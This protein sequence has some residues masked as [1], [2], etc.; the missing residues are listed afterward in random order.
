[1][2][3]T[4]HIS[5][6]CCFCGGQIDETKTKAVDIQVMLEE[7]AIQGLTAHRKCLAK[8]L[9]PSVPIGLDIEEETGL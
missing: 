1:M 4:D 3:K 6:Q 2:R 5:F 8:A 9:H 7:G